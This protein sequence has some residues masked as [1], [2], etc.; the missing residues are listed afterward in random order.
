MEHH[1]G[2]VVLVGWSVNNRLHRN[3]GNGSGDAFVCWSVGR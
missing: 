1:P 2:W 3:A